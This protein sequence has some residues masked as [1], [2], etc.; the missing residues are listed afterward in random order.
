MKIIRFEDPLYTC[1]IVYCIGTG[2]EFDEYCRSKWGYEGEDMS[3]GRDGMTATLRCADSGV[4]V[5]M[6]WLKEE[7]IPILCHETYHVVCKVLK[8][9]GIPKHEEHVAY[10]IEHYMKKVLKKLKKV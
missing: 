1:T 8:S 6:V 9:L 4:Y 3:F 7:D 5:F 10:M 2:E